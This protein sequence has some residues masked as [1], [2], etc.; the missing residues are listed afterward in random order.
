MQSIKKIH[1]DQRCEL[2]NGLHRILTV[3]RKSDTCW[4]NSTDIEALCDPPRL[5][6]SICKRIPL[7]A[8]RV[9]KGPIVLT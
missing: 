9:R 3:D 1:T 6:S 7:E 4:N 8:T 5:H 2:K